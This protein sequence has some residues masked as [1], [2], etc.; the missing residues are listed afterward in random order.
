MVGL[1]GNMVGLCPEHGETG[2]EHGPL[3]R[4]MVGWP[5]TWSAGQEHGPLARNMEGLAVHVVYCIW[6]ATRRV[7]LGTL[8]DRTEHL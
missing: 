7:R 5:G 4:N 1:A 3:A 6:P 8:W 2:R